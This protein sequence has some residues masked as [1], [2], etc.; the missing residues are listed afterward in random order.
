MLVHLA[1][2]MRRGLTAAVKSELTASSLWV[3]YETV[4]VFGAFTDMDGV[5]P[6]VSR[7]EAKDLWI[8]EKIASL[9]TVPLKSREKTQQCK[10]SSIL[11]LAVVKY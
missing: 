10:I 4:V 5:E 9:L 7:L 1:F 6:V 2:V 11:L 8:L 3:G